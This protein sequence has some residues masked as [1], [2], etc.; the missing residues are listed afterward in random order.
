MSLCELDI[1]R[2][3]AEGTLPS[4]TTWMN[5]VYVALRISGTGA[6]WRN[7]VQ[8]FV[9]RDK[10]DWCS[11]GFLCRCL[12]LPVVIE[13]PYTG[14][15]TSRYF[16]DRVVGVILYSYVHPE[17]DEPWGVMRCLDATAAKMIGAGVF[18]TSPGI[19]ISP[20]DCAMTEVDGKKLLVEGLPRLLD[21]CALVYT[22]EGNKGV[23]TR[24]NEDGVGVDSVAWSAAYDYA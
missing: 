10:N 22:G 15:L 12:G 3:I 21:H 9:Y 4:P 14:T 19:V 13:H 5:V 1:A 11:A 17:L 7:S 16:G 24:D 18:D 6:A 2:A 8:E 23:W 20:E